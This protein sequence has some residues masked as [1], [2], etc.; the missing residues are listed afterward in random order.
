MGNCLTIED[1][2]DELK[3]KQIASIQVLNGHT[4]SIKQLVETQ[5]KHVTH[6]I[7]V[8]DKRRAWEGTYDKDG[9]SIKLQI[10][11]TKVVSKNELDN[12]TE[13]NVDMEAAT[14]FRENYKPQSWVSSYNGSSL[15]YRF[16]ENYLELEYTQ[17][18]EMLWD[19]MVEIIAHVRI[20]TSA[21]SLYSSL[22]QREEW[23]SEQYI[24]Q[25]VQTNLKDDFVKQ[26]APD[27]VPIRVVD[28]DMNSVDSEEPELGL[29]ISTVLE[30]LAD[31]KSTFKWS[32]VA[33]SWPI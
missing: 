32:N 26:I 21:F 25:S 24:W 18:V 6:N 31:E 7:L 20:P 33:I 27:L 19:S 9:L 3:Q 16:Y 13:G 12:W 1:A 23:T 29:P 11:N 17:T 28:E 8:K 5:L 14:K 10:V 15:R 30:Y 2:V 22:D 4:S